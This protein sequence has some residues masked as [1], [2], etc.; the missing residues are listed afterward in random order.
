MDVTSARLLIYSNSNYLTIKRFMLIIFYINKTNNNHV[1]L[2]FLVVKIN[3][4]ALY[5]ISTSDIFKISQQNFKLMIMY[6]LLAYN[7][8]GLANQN[9][10]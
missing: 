1:L 5:H 4:I 7:L 9:Q 6:I 2:L 10:A 8:S 3:L